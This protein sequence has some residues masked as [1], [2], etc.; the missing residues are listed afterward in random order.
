MKKTI[1]TY[2]NL[3]KEFENFFTRYL[4]A[5]RGI[6][7]HT[8]RSYRDAFVLLIDYFDKIKRISPERLSLEHFTKDNI[9]S[10]LDWIESNGCSSATRNIRCAAIKSFVNYL[11]FNDPIHMAQW[12]LIS[13]I[14]AKK[15]VKDTFSHLTVE[16]MTKLLENIDLST[17]RGRRD[18]VILS[19]LYYSGARA[20]ELADLTPSSIRL[21]EPYVIEL[22]GKG[23]K[24]RCV[25][26]DVDIIKLLK[27]YMR[28]FSLDRPERNRHPLFFNTW[29]EKLTT[30]GLKYI[31][32]KH[33]NPVR[34]IYPELFP[35][36]ISPHSFRHSRAMHL[37]QSGVNIVILRDML[38]YVSIQTTEIYAR[39][40]SKQKRD[41]ILNAY[42][43]IGRVEPEKTSWEKD[44]KLKSF[45]K[46][47][48]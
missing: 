2:K 39:V 10:Y 43:A 26:L 48:V 16:A 4:I 40:D 3:G 31:I 33:V 1:E 14:K 17:S 34:I 29:G 6:S 5:E 25:P 24:K 37:L 12:Q 20:Q 38:G 42:K 21:S 27:S 19:I 22:L 15:T 41:A 9:T 36:K 44:P 11:I 45:L 23:S 28:E 7:Q 13:S 32:D 46:R 18:H 35:E 30:A 8:L 47:L